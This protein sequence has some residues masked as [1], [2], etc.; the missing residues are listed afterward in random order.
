A[1]PAGFI[2][3]LV[4]SQGTDPSKFIGFSQDEETS[5]WLTGYFG[6]LLKSVTFDG[7]VVIGFL[8]IMAVASWIVMVEKHGYLKRHKK[9]NDVF[10]DQFR[11]MRGDLTTL[12][13]TTAAQSGKRNPLANSS[14]FRIYRIGAGEIRGR[15]PD[16]AQ[17]S[18]HPLSAEAIAAI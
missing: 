15:F 14:L 11:R 4:A 10:V 1:R 7:W 16:D 18:T 9:G 12:L 2:K 3:A 13:D 17:G 8:L 6:V 5:S